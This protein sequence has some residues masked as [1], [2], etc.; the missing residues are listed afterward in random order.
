MVANELSDTRVELLAGSAV[1]DSAEPSSGTSVTLI[2]RNWN[3]HFFERGGKG[4][5]A[6]LGLRFVFRKTSI[7]TTKVSGVFASP[8]AVWICPAMVLENSG[9]E[10]RQKSRKHAA[11]RHT[12][13]LT[14]VLLRTVDFG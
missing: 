4:Q 6:T 5:N 1:V 11:R 12:R 13:R 2:Y 7:R 10:T 14:A 9:V 3:V 8:V